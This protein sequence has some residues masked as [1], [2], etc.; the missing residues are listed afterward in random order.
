MNWMIYQGL[1]SKGQ[2]ELASVI[3]NDTLSLIEKYDFHEYFEAQKE[4]AKDLQCG[5]GGKDFSWTSSTI[6]HLSSE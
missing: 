4:V 5:Y 3:K 2:N 1:K 6:I